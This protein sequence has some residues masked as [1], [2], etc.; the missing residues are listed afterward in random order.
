MSQTVEVYL[1]PSCRSG[2]RD[3]NFPYGHSHCNAPGYE[4]PA[5]GWIDVPCGC[6]CHTKTTEAAR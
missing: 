2:K 6:D 4:H 3:P 5:L 1:T